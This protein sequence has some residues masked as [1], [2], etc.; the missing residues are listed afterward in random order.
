[1]VLIQNCFA[2]S[3][4]LVII[5]LC[6]IPSLCSNPYHL[7]FFSV[8]AQCQLLRE[9][10]F[11]LISFRVRRVFMCYFIRVFFKSVD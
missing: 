5:I 9:V 3:V 7:F 1:M 4:T 2:S 11:N 6:E 8:V 10:L